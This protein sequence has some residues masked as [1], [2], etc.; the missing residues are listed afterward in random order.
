MSRHQMRLLL[1]SVAS[2]ALIVGATLVLEWLHV[3]FGPSRI[4]IGMRT[5]RMCVPD[6]GCRSV[7]LSGIGGFYPMLAALGFWCG[8][9]LA[10]LL[11]A[12]LLTKTITGSANP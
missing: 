11:V 4:S 10:L 5:A 8:L 2:V 12:Q 6:E 1:C 7:S 9:A 3:D